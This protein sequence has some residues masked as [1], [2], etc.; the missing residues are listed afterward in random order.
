MKNI[1]VF[2]AIIAISFPVLAQ[3]NIYK[4]AGVPYTT[5]TPDWAPK[6]KTESEF[7]IDSTTGKWWMYSYQDVSWHDLGSFIYETGTSGAPAYTPNKVTSPLAINAGDSIYHYR[8]SAWHLVSGAGGGSGTVT[9]VNITQP[10]AGIT[11]SG[12]PIISS[13]AITLALAN[14]L[15]AVEGLSGTGI[16]VRTGS[17]TWQTRTITASS[18]FS[19]SNADGVSGNPAISLSQQGATPGQVLSWNGS[20]W[21]P[22]TVAS[23]VTIDTFEINSNT[24]YLS[25]DGDGEPAKTVDLSSYLDNTDAQTL[26]IDSSSVTNGQNFEISISNGNT[27]GLFVPSVVT[28]TNIYN[29]SG[30]ILADTVRA[31]NLD[32][33]SVLNFNYPNSTTAISIHAGDDS[34]GVNGYVYMSSPDSTTLKLDDVD[35]FKVYTPL[36]AEIEFGDDQDSQYFSVHNTSSTGNLYISSE[37]IGLTSNDIAQEV[38]GTI[39]LDTFGRAVI[40]SAVGGGNF[41]SVGFYQTQGEG[42]YIVN[43]GNLPAPGQ[44]LVAQSDQTFAF[45]DIDTLI[46]ASFGYNIYNSDGNIN[47]SVNRIMTFD[48]LASLAMS[49]P[50]GDYAIEIYAGDDSTAVDGLVNINSPD[51]QSTLAITDQAVTMA[52]AS[53]SSDIL[54]SDSGIR[55]RPNGSTG[56]AGQILASDGS[57]VYWKDS[58]NTTGWDTDVSN[59]LDGSG[60]TNQVA[61]WSDANTLTG[62]NSMVYETNT[63]SFYPTSNDTV[64][65]IHTPAGRNFGLRTFTD[66]L[67]GTTDAVEIGGLSGNTRVY[68]TGYEWIPKMNFRQYG[69]TAGIAFAGSTGSLYLNTNGDYYSATLA[70]D[71]QLTNRNVSFYFASGGTN[72]GNPVIFQQAFAGN[73]TLSNGFEFISRN[74]ASGGI[75]HPDS[76]LMRFTSW[77]RGIQFNQLQDGKL[78]LQIRHPLY[79]LD[80]N[81]VDGVRLPRGNTG[82]RPASTPAGVLRFNTDSLG[83]EYADGS[84]WILIGSGSSGTGTN[85]YNSDGDVQAGGTIV[86]VSDD[87][88]IVFYLDNGAGQTNTMTRWE[89]TYDTDDAT[90]HFMKL[91]TPGDS[92]YISGFDKSITFNYEGPTNGTGTALSFNSNTT[93]TLSADSLLV[94]TLPTKSVLHSIAG[95]YNGTLSSV[96]GTTDGDYLVWNTA[97]YWEVG[98][99]GSGVNLYN[100]NGNIL[101][102]VTRNVNLDSLSYLNVKYPNGTTALGLFG[103]NDSTG[104][105]GSVYLQDFTGNSYF[106]ID[107]VGINGFVDTDAGRELYLSDL[108]ELN[109]IYLNGGGLQLVS[110]NLRAGDVDANDTG[111]GIR[112]ASS[113]PMRIGNV[114]GDNDTYIDMYATGD[115]DMLIKDG[116]EF[117]LSD[118]SGNN[119][120]TQ[121]QTDFE[122]YG[123]DNSGA[124]YYSINATDGV[125]PQI[126]LQSYSAFG[127]NSFAFIDTFG[128]KLHTQ[129]SSGTAGQMLYSDGTYSYWDDAP[130]GADG[131]GIYTAS[132]TIPDGTAA[133]IQ[134]GGDFRINYFNDNSA[135]GVDDVLGQAFIAGEDGTYAVYADNSNAGI[136]AGSASW[137]VGSTYAL[138]GTADVANT[139]T[140]A[141]RLI[142]QTNSTGTASAGFGGAIL[143]QGES[144]T[145]D[146]RDMARLQTDWVTATDGS[147]RSQFKIQ[148]VQ[149]GTINDYLTL[150]TGG[151]SGGQL[152]LGYSS[153][154]SISPTAFT[155]GTNY[156]FGG[157][158][159][160]VTLGGSSG[161]VNVGNSSGQVQVTSSY[162]GDNGINI[163]Q[164]SSSGGI[165]ISNNLNNASGSVFL[166]YN[167]TRSNQNTTF[168][169]IRIGRLYNYS[170]TTSGTGSHVDLVFEGTI[171]QTGTANQ[172]T[173]GIQINPTLTAVV[174]Y[175]AIE[176]AAN[177]TS[178]KGIYQTGSSTTNNFVGATGFG[179]TTTPTDKLEVTGNIALLTAGNKMKI[180]TGSNASVGTATLSSGTITVNTT[181]VTA[182]SLIFVSYDTPSGTTG[183]LSAPSG[184]IVAGTS[185][186]INSTSGSDASTVY[187]W[188][189]N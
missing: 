81:D 68:M 129:G 105:N 118:Q 15:A 123:S 124:S 176:I 71:N 172:I 41:G 22:T 36:I 30:N 119:Y 96:V 75:T 150:S 69:G 17:D 112:L 39:E 179:S 10:V 108:N 149:S 49:Y 58:L 89:A 67:N 165:V 126:I 90:T 86:D 99:A 175:R 70:G 156:T 72:K 185:F 130:T 188:I 85:I 158:S 163:A 4:A 5:G 178:A 98:A 135:F 145:T 143:F 101:T 13:G 93:I 154:V 46:P 164:N 21:A 7:A 141:D 181:A 180:A 77:D 1:L 162:S 103:G 115:I 54:V 121:T 9:S 138:T 83:L 177:S 28:N 120:I 106:Q 18:E 137:L 65:S 45:A 52:N 61:V 6:Q 132:G 182:S 20:A 66:P 125:N 78:G 166:G 11:T 23:S 142:L 82:E 56:T 88:Q 73:D 139:N 157:T 174:D 16:V 34:T 80:I 32:S 95:K 170:P 160:S 173:R 91:V 152:T 50:T 25:L 87:D 48:T 63:L 186:V 161:T 14:D 42:L 131:N 104:T 59:D 146:N 167:L 24:L 97:G 169:N 53:S 29:S 26:S 153:G 92:L 117:L 134:D 111:L 127:G 35:G 57:F 43:H 110:E 109:Y 19:L 140:A 189:I 2:L 148:L 31:V 38:A 183:Q 147:R 100:S 60:A 40:S 114:Y 155:P 133:T 51:G 3:K 136:T 151:G 159:S 55:I 64:F 33:T 102:G 84:Q 107:D 47:G 74:T 128:I 184:S 44:L 8:S 187:W 37:S 113:T 144:S 122:V 76:T 27:I 12:G 168:K 94:G 62:Y 79:S 116:G 171:N